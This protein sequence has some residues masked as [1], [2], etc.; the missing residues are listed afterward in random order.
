MTFK[1]EWELDNHTLKYIAGNNDFT[2]LMDICSWGSPGAVVTPNCVYPVVRDQDYEQTSHELQL[3]SES[4]GPLNYTLG[5]FYIETEAN[6]DSGP[7]GNFRSQQEA[8]AQAVFADFSYDV[9]E[10]W[11]LG[12]GLRYTEEEKEFAIQ[13]YASFA[14]KIARDPVS[15][16]L[17]RDFKDDNLQHKIVL[18][19]NT[20]FGMVYLSHST[21]FRSGG[22]NAR[23]STPE[24]VGPFNSEEVETIELGI[25]SELLD[26]RL[27]L[28]LT[29]FTNDYTDKQEV[30]VTA[31]DG[32][33]VVD[34][35]PQFCGT[36]C[37]F[38]RN[39][40]QVSIDGIEL[41]GTY[42]ATQALT[43]RSAIGILDSGYDNFE[44]DGQ[45]VA[46]DAQLN[47]A[48]DYT[49]SISFDYV[50][51]V[52]NG[53]LIFAGTLSAKDKFYGRFDPAVYNYELGANMAVDKAEKLD[54]SVTYNRD[55]S[56][57]GTMTLTVFGK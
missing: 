3:I 53:E 34:G 55:L 10:D 25:R 47:F 26:N 51:N 30:I 57:G 31:A 52:Q 4:D 2:E 41:E 14:D 48:P 28:N 20:D 42:R 39:A 19:R 16:A 8:E 45:N 33:I 36:T 50:T 6:M 23:G 32:S 40:G 27:I 9:S 24:S 43:L 22:F 49:A 11:T 7:V 44:Y 13:N 1:V 12:L 54:L 29:A 35:V 5:L 17:A 21:G 56:N 38:V 37:T 18:Q 46:A 15:L